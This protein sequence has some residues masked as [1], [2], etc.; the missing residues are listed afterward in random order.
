MNNNQQVDEFLQHY[1]IPG[2]RWGVRKRRVQVSNSS[3]RSRRQNVDYDNPPRR[4]MSNK[5]LNA[6]VKRL[7]LEQEYAKLTA[8]PETPSKIEKAIKVAGTVATLSATAW[9]IYENMDKITKA[10]KA[11]KKA[12]N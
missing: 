6:R 5:E 11:A 12:M 2:M 3:N 9:K 4:R 7:R 1:G 10:A 8:R